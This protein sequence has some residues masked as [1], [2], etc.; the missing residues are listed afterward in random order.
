[1]IERRALQALP[2]NAACNPAM[3]GLTI[4]SRVARRTDS[5]RREHH[6][7][8]N[9]GPCGADRAREECEKHLVEMMMVMVMHP[10]S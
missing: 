3:S 7:E 6:D 2:S 1:V 8:Q 5:D 9:R 4:A 10:G